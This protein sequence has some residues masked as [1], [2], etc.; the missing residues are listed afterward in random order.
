[1]SF[2]IH[3]SWK[4]LHIS[5][6]D[7]FLRIGWKWGIY[8]VMRVILGVFLFFEVGVFSFFWVFFCLVESSFTWHLISRLLLYASLRMPHS[9]SLV[10][11]RSKKLS[12]LLLLSAS[13]TPLLSISQSLWQLN[14]S[15]SVSYSPQTLQQMIIWHVP[16]N[17]VRADSGKRK[18]H[19]ITK[20]FTITTITT[21]TRQL[22]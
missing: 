2:N 16:V 7:T 19:Y 11:H 9:F 8:K 1:M 22:V 6:H 10:S 13:E 4:F 5:F 17:H 3:V 12:K 15:S 18:S 20:V 21:T 14:R